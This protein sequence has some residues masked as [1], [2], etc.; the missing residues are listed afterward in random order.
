MT[1]PVAVTAL[2]GRASAALLGRLSGERNCIGGTRALFIPQ[3]KL[4]VLLKVEHDLFGFERDFCGRGLHVALNHS[5]HMFVATP[6]DDEEGNIDKCFLCDPPGHVISMANVVANFPAIGDLVFVASDAL[7]ECILD[8]IH[9][10]D[11]PLIKM[12]RLEGLET[13]V[14]GVNV[15]QKFA[16][17]SC[18]VQTDIRPRHP[19]VGVPIVMSNRLDCSVRN[20]GG[21]LREFFDMV[22]QSTDSEI[23]ANFGSPDFPVPDGLVERISG[24]AGTDAHYSNTRAERI[25]GIDRGGDISAMMDVWIA[26]GGRK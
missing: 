23:I 10:F 4:E 25:I 14:G 20:N 7:G 16:F 3:E 21:T 22:A 9:L 18:A 13:F 12:V 5:M 6:E 17:N 24:E 26:S 1:R 2:R 11:G 15:V 19:I 8:K